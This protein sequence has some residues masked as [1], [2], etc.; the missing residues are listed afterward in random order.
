MIT[1][2]TN[3]I[4]NKLKSNVMKKRTGLLSVAV[5]TFFAFNSTCSLAQEAACKP[6]AFTV[7]ALGAANLSMLYAGSLEINKNYDFGVGYNVGITTSYAFYNSWSLVANVNFAKLN[8]ERKDMQPLL[9][10]P[11]SPTAPALFANYKKTESFDYIEVPV[12]ARYTT[13]DKIKVY[14]NA[15]PYLGFIASSRVLTSGRSMIYSDLGGN[16]P[17]GGN[18]TVYSLDGNRTTTSSMSTVNFGVTGGL[19]AGYSFGKHFVMVDARYN[20]GL[21]NIRN[22]A[23]INGKNNMQTLMLGLG[24]SYELFK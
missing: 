23:E 14:V 24:Y 22:A 10:N 12:M 5:A 3:F 19:G 11:A 20:V 18:T 2:Q 7:G 9:P 13:G 8:T 17:E 15:G 6:H 4:V 1:N 21:T 16:V